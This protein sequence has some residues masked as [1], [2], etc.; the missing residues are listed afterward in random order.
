MRYGITI[1]L[2]RPIGHVGALAAHAEKL[3]FDELWLADH[4]YNRDVAVAL[5]LMAEHTE[6][7]TL[8]TAVASPFLRH[9]TL[10]AS[11][12]GTI[13]ELAGERFVL[14]LGSGGYEFGQEM[15]ISIKRPLAAIAESTRIVR[16][17]LAGRADV[18]GD[19]FSARG[20][21]LRW[22]AARTPVHLAARGPKMLALAGEIADGVITHGIS[23]THIDYV[24]DKTGGGTDVCLMLDVE[25]GDDQRGAYE[26]L[27]PRCLMMAGGSYADELIDVYGLPRD[28]VAALRE[29]VRTDG[30]ERAAEL[31]TDDIAAA[32]GIAGP[33][34][35]VREQLGRLDARGVDSVIL[36][37]GG[38]TADEVA[39]HMTRLAEAVHG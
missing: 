35:H 7:P 37:V 14:G 9:P 39:D 13:G 34:S 21:A 27:R 2:D 22:P 3:G 36:S 26:R 31:V 19:V 5:T 18:A 12:A 33:V 30:R 32:F 15:E 28:Q 38:G 16:E 17:L 20:S 6:T 23:D 25:V 1:P 24:R 10:L 8:G 29:A 11:L 4:Y